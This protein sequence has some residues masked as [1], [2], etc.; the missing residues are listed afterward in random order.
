MTPVPRCVWTCPKCGKIELQIH[1]LWDSD[2]I[3]MRCD[4]CMLDV[5]FGENDPTRTKLVPKFMIVKHT[6]TICG[7]DMRNRDFWEKLFELRP[8]VKEMI[9]VGK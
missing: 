2:E 8:D 7:L 4:D 6:F 3:I 5:I 1:K 9:D